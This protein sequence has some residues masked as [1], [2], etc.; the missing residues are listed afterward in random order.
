MYKRQE[1]K[2]VAHARPRRI[3]TRVQS[4]TVGAPA[5]ERPRAKPYAARAVHEPTA[6]E[7]AVLSY[8]FDQER[9]PVAHSTPEHSAAE[10]DVHAASPPRQ[11]PLTPRRT[12]PEAGP[13]A[14][15]KPALEILCS[16]SLP[17]QRSIDDPASTTRR[18][19]AVG[20]SPSS[21]D[22]ISRA[23]QNYVDGVLAQE[24]AAHE[25]ALCRALKEA[26]ERSEARAQSLRLRLYISETKCADL[27]QSV[28]ELERA[29]ERAAAE[30]SFAHASASPP[31][32]M[33]L[34]PPPSP[35]VS[36]VQ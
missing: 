14:P 30:R 2:H 19:T 21:L 12:S 1:W 27:E 26:H 9:L 16:Q 11:P 20:A 7:Q 22:T 24:R 25:A 3:G 28:R 13:P 32:A 4:G 36:N 15:A 33:A 8:D 31:T 29:A 17:P 5:A 23:L 35:L 10:R 34:T 18:D 6:C